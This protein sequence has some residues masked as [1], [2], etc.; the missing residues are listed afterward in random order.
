MVSFSWILATSGPVIIGLV[1]CR[2][3]AAIAPPS[4]FGLGPR[5]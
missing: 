3:L 2:Y 5:G 1:T 4:E